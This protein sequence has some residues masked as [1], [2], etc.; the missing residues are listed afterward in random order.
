MYNFRLNRIII[1]FLPIFVFLP[2]IYNLLSNFHTGG[3]SLF[4]EFLTSA[5]TPKINN[6][7][8][9]IALIRISETIFIS[10]LSWL[11]SLV[12][13]VVLGILISDIFYK[14]IKIPIFIKSLIK[15]PLIIFRSIHEMIW[16]LMLIQLFGISKEIGIFS[17]CIS[18]ST[19]NAKVISEQLEIID[20]KTIESIN[21]YKGNKFAS[22]I[23]LIWIPI[24]KIINNF[25]LYRFECAIRSSSI[26][27]IFGIGG[28][29]TS[30]FLSFQALNFREMWTYIW[31]LAILIIISKQ[32][33]NHFNKL[34]FRPRFS[35]FLYLV[36]LFIVIFSFYFT[37][38]LLTINN[39][40]KYISPNRLTLIN[41]L[42]IPNNYF[43]S[44]IE[45]INLSIFSS[46]I[47]ISLPP[48]I[49]LISQNK[50]Y[51]YCL[52]I[53]A[54]WIRV[55][56]P[57]IILLIL[58][59]FNN[60]SLSLAAITLGLHNASITFKL[61]NNNLIQTDNSEYLAIKS[62]SVSNRVSW[63][64]GLFAKQSKSYLAYCAYRSDILIRETAIM[65]VIGSIG[66]GWQFNEAL[67]S[68]AWKEVI[69]ILFAYSSI[70]IIGE[71]INGKIKDKLIK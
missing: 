52:K 36:A 9:S 8:I 41:L 32:I 13:G 45:T 61:L 55:I 28:I 53:L 33:L 17:M 60:P 70:A 7:I 29:G 59:M 64:Y 50:Y 16:C 58:L 14:F 44:I 34:K 18:F 19:I 49:L 63:L 25:G 10:F 67:S 39:L 3:I 2:L 21:Q 42:S 66:L 5:L 27:G 1:C 47:A 54:F 35:I 30:I 6:E 22:L 26:L 24:Y 48:T 51:I 56:P 46:A 15:F 12:L 57:P 4:F 31:F 37:F 62:F 20:T 40:F 43:I 65:G 69:T 23:T 38:N 71:L 68:F 11:I